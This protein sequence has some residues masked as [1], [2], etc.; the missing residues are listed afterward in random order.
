MARIDVPTLQCDRCKM[1]TTVDEIMSRFNTLTGMYDKCQGASE[2]WDLCTFC[3][4]QFLQFTKN[5]PV[6]MNDLPH[7]EAGIQHDGDRT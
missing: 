3:W 5:M 4:G 6:P 2:R 7:R 1:S